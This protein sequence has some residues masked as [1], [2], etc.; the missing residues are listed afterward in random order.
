VR[1]PRATGFHL[2]NYDPADRLLIATAT[3]L[4]C[5]IVSYD[6]R[7]LNFARRHGR[8]YGFSASA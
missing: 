3:E 2:E 8:R 1:L 5:P 6:E 7:F 4:N